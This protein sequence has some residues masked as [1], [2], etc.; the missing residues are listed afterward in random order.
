MPNL[1]K[2]DFLIVGGGIAGLSAAL[3]ASKY[4]KVIIL[5][6]DKISETATKKAQ[7]GIAAAIDQI[8][9]STEFHFE[10][11][12]NAGAGL[13]EEESVR[14]LV[15]E[16]VERVKELI[17][18]GA[19]F[20]RAETEAGGGFALALEGA[21]KRRRILHAGDATGEEIQ[22]TLGAKI[23]ADKLVN[24][25]QHT[26][27]IDLIIENGKCIGVKALDLKNK[28]IKYFLAKA[29]I[30]TTGGLGQAYHYTTNPEVATG[31]G[32]A[33]AYRAGA[34]VTDMEFVQ[35][36]PTSL[37]QFEELKD[38]I[39]LPR[40]LISEAVRGEG[41]VLLNNKDERF[42][43]KYDTQKELAP[44][45]IVSR[46]IYQEMQET[47]SDHV[48][49]SLA[50]LDHEKIKKRFP[51]IYKTCL[52]R[53]LD[54]TR[55][56]IPVAPAAHYFMGGIKTDIEGRTKTPGLY[57]AGECASLGIHGANRLA[58]NSL[59]DGLVFGHRS[60]AAAK[61]ETQDTRYKIQDTKHK[62]TS[63]KGSIANSKLKEAEL[64]R[65]KLIIKSSMWDNVGIVRSKESLTKALKLI[66]EVEKRLNYSPITKEEIEL[67]NLT[68]VSKLTTKAALDRTESRGAHYRRDFPKT[69][70]KNWKKHLEYHLN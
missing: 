18:M 23:V 39:A 63:K 48:H 36:H 68:L 52:E 34:V 40:F 22:R 7:G 67:K 12:I 27:G 30:I 24:I 26:L 8:K 15:T 19:R 55:D 62:A 5:T 70:D 65:F 37:V 25:H 11:T 9:D 49:L 61:H 28:C 14:I 59:L 32:I 17:Q 3:E 47:R 46:A 13:C 6:K 38:I 69:D 31:D 64:K 4:G 2:C 44:R 57:A 50:K 29:T 66:G 58:S 20:D 35:F 42:M 21:H 45:D 51:V 41:A 33:M 56:N 1:E 53:G 16:G 54:I 60:A 10:D 43:E